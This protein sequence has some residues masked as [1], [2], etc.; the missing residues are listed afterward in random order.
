V[1][2]SEHDERPRYGAESPAA[3]MGER[4]EPIIDS[5][6]EPDDPPLQDTPDF[7][8][9][10]Q[11]DPRTRPQDPAGTRPRVHP[12]S[13]L[14][15]RR[16]L[17]TAL[18]RI[19]HPVATSTEDEDL[20]PALRASAQAPELAHV[21]PPHAARFQFMLG[22]LGA[23]AVAAVAIGVF[24][25]ARPAP[26]PGP[27]WS[28]WRPTSGAVDPAIQIAGHVMPEYRLDDGSPLV[29]VTG[30]PL[31][32]QGQQLPVAMRVSGSEP[33]ELPGNGVFYQ[34]CGDG[35]SC[36]I[37]GTASIQRGLLLR[38]EA[39]ELALYSLRYIRGVDQVVVTFPPP[40][41]STKKTATAASQ[42]PPRALFFQPSG[43]GP[44][45]QR[46]LS[47][48]L[49]RSTPTVAT[50]NRSADSGLVNQLT[51]NALYDFTITQD[52]QSNPVLLLAP[53]G[54]GG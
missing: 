26:S 35:P 10:N 8:E 28:S 18:H 13:L 15:E 54:L 50:V 22:A 39:L 33:S 38:R 52:Q 17:P 43:L 46:P 53:P 1:S 29:R 40:P 34:L 7:A 23:L 19:A 49:T 24:L 42:T 14:P 20:L 30:G 36:S 11:P 44:E 31:S 48:T 27:A 12:D 45:L 16:G 21:E 37:A 41:P 25:I 5:T 51:S 32:Y 3:E 2:R 9:A 47:G 4:P 6:A